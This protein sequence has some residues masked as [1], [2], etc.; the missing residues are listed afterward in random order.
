LALNDGA[1]AVLDLVE[2]HG[3]GEEFLASTMSG[4]ALIAIGAASDLV[5][6]SALDQHTVVPEMKER[7]IELGRVP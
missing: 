6:C 3:L 7:R 4:R 5:L 1:R 2:I